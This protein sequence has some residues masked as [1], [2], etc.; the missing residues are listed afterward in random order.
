[1]EGSGRGESRLGTAT[2]ATFP[3][4]PRLTEVGSCDGDRILFRCS[5]GKSVDVVSSHLTGKYVFKAMIGLAPVLAGRL[6]GYGISEGEE[7]LG[8][9]GDA[10]YLRLAEALEACHL[11]PATTWMARHRS[12][13]LVRAQQVRESSVGGRVATPLTD[14]LD[15]PRG[16]DAIG[17]HPQEPLGR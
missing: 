3:G 17:R 15:R 8:L 7:K 14:P 11:S 6:D 13:L 12:E 10:S 5:D 16:D 2:F 1:M 9:P 4:R